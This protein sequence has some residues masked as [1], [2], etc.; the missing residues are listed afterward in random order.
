MRAKRLRLESPPLAG[1]QSREPPEKD[2]KDMDRLVTVFGGSGF[3]GR[4]V[5]RAL[6]RAGWRVRA[7]VRRPDLAG[8]LQPLGIL[9]QILAVQ[10]NLRYPESV[11]AAVE[12]SD[13]VVNAVGI[14]FETGRQRFASVHAQGA[15]TVAEAA[16]AIGAR[17]VHVSAIGADP[18]SRSV[19]GRTKAEGEARVRAAAPDAV[20]L[21]PSI[22]FGP[23]DGFFNL[24]AG[25][26]RLSPVLP[27]VGGGKT[28]FQPVYVG[29]VAKAALA[30]AEGAAKPGIYELGGPEV[31]TF[32]ELI[33]L[34]LAVTER[35]RLLVPLPFWAAYL[36]ASVL[37][38]LPNPLLTPDQVTLLKTHNIVSHAAIDA[39][40]TLEGLGITPTALL[41]VLPSYLGRFRRTGQFAG[42]AVV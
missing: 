40:R 17:M 38:F 39:G 8:H 18:E 13:A 31:K 41:T 42:S 33:E 23:E 19:Y 2:W 16:A 26:A 20:I 15:G 14:L 32:K 34:I 1:A 5:V 30:G 9:G 29:D 35:K 3:V 24:F 10:A 6:A 21:R 36:Q 27:L 22:V 11:R 4:H 12:G 28:C 7:A 25:L 37:Q